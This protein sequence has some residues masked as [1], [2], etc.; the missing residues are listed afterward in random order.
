MSYILSNIS[1]FRFHRVPPQVLALCPSIPDEDCD[2]QRLLLRQDLLVNHV[3]GFPLHTLA[4]CKNSI[5]RG[6]LL[7]RH[8]WSGRLPPEVIWETDHGVQV[9]SPLFT[10]LTVAP[11][12]S[13]T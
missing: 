3:L 6:A 13:E 4:F 8:L 12:I 10:L 1:A 11:Y 7:E 5:T 2:R 9:A